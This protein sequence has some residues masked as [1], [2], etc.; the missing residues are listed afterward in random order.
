VKIGVAAIFISGVWVRPLG[1]FSC[2]ALCYFSEFG[3][4]ASKSFLLEKSMENFA[5]LVDP[6]PM[7]ADTRI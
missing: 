5:S 3:S 2:M 4:F 6:V 7:T 1:T